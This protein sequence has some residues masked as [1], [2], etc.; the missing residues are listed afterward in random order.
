MAGL[1]GRIL[2]CGA[3]IPVFGSRCKAFRRQIWD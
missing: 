1:A 3:L 2:D